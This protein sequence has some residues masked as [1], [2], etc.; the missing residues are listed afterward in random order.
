MADGDEDAGQRD[1]AR[2]ATIARGDADAGDPAVVAQYFLQHVVPDDLDL[3]FLLTL[4]Q[5]VLQDLLRAQRV[6]AVHQRDL[7]ADVAEVQRFLDGRVAAADHRHV[8]L[9]VEEAVAGG[10]GGNTLALEGLFG[11]QAEVLGRGAGGD[12]QAVSGVAAVVALELERTLRQVDLIDVV[13]HDLGI[14]TLGVRLHALHQRRAL[15][16]FHVAWPV[17]DLGGGHQLAT[18]LKPGDQHRL[19][20]G[21]RRVDGS[22][23]AGGAGTENKQMTMA[24]RG[25][26]GRHV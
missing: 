22:G 21:A 17:V 5:L 4:E 12:D 20:V 15:Q 19:Q 16:P 23:V 9:A 18:L 25:T 1:V 2:I 10:T 8:L 24:G 14:E 7:A 11:W 3:A 13:E 26:G 6:A